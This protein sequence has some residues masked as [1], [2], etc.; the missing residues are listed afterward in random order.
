MATGASC[1]AV[2]IELVEVDIERRLK[3]GEPACLADYFERYPQLAAN[4]TVVYAPPQAERSTGPLPIPEE[5]GGYRI[6]RILGQGSFGVVYLGYDHQLHR[7]VAIKVPHR[8]LVARPEDAAPYRA[9]ARVVAALNHPNIVPV[10]HVGSAADHPF[11]IVSKFIKG[12]TLARRI[13]LFRPSV[14]EAAKLA[15]VVADAL[16]YAHRQ[17][18]VHRDIKPG[19][20]LLERQAGGGQPLL[21]YVADFGL[22][23]REQDFGKGAGRVGTPAYMSPE[24]ARGEGN[25]V[26]GRSDIFSLGVVFYELLTGVR[27]FQADTIEGILDQI[28]NADVRPPRQRDDSIPPELER[29]CLK[30]LARRASERYTTAKDFA[31]DLRSFLTETAA[32]DESGSGRKRPDKPPIKIVP[33]GLR[34]FQAHDADFFLELLPGPRDRHGLPD[35]IR[36][37][38]TRIEDKDEANTFSVG[39]IYGPSG[40]GKSSLVKAGLL[41]RLNE[42]VIAVYIEASTQETEA[43]L[44]SGLR[45][46]FDRETSAGH[47][48]AMAEPASLG[49]RDTL[50]AVRR[51]QILPSGK[52]VLIVLDQFEQWLHGAASRRRRR[53]ETDSA[54]LV[55]ALRQCDGRRVQCLVMVRDDFWLAVSRFLQELE[56]PLLEGQNS[57]LVDLFDLEHAKKVLAAFGRAF[58][59]LP[60]DPSETSKEQRQFLEQAVTDL[61][62]EGK[63][64]CV[65]L[66]LFAEMMKSK[67]WT[68]GSLKAVGGAT[69]ISAKFLEETFGRPTAPPAHLHHRD[70]AREVLQALLPES[71]TN[72][73]GHMRSYQQLLEASG[74]TSGSR[75]TSGKNFDDLLH[76]LDSDLRLITP[77]DPEGATRD[78]EAEIRGARHGLGNESRAS[79]SSS[80]LPTPSV[81]RRFYQLTHDYLVHSLRDWLS[82]EEQ[83][84]MRGRTGLLMKDLASVYS[85]RTENRQLPSFFQWIRI[86][87][88]TSNKTWTQPQRRMMG[89]AGRYHAKRALRLAVLLLLSTLVGLY[90]YRANRAAELV[91]FLEAAE[92]A[93]VPGIV[94]EIAPYR[95]WANARLEE[96]NKKAAADSRRKL[97]TSMALLPVQPEQAEYL[98]G[99]LLDA[100]LDFGR[101]LDAKPNLIRVILDF[102]ARYPA[103]GDCRDRIL[104]GLV[105]EV[106]KLPSSNAEEDA[107]ETLSRRQAKAA[108]ALLRMN[109]PDQV[110]PL[111]KHRED[112]RVRSYLIHLLGPSGV[113]FKHIS[114][115]LRNE[116]DLTIRQALV[117]SLGDFGEEDIAGDERNALVNDLREWYVHHPDPGLHGAAEWLLRQWKQ[118][119]WL[120]ET[121]ERRVTAKQQSEQRR[122]VIRQGFAKDGAA[123]RVPQW[124]VNSQGQTMVV[125][126]S[127]T[128]FMMGSPLKEESRWPD[129]RLQQRQNIG[130]RFA[131]AAKSVTVDQFRR[132]RKSHGPLALRRPSKPDC[133]VTWLS[134]HLAAEYCNWLSDQEGLE[135]CYEPIDK[136]THEAEMK[137]AANC[138]SRTGYRLPTEEEWECACRAGTRTSR[139]YGEPTELLRKYG[140]YVENSGNRSWEVA[141]LKPNDWGLF[142]MHGNV[143]NW[144]H[145]EYDGSRSEN[146]RFSGRLV[147]R[148]G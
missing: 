3:C 122:E 120:K 97:N 121:D 44:L 1:R 142:D 72:I 20:I 37:W 73:K 104:T 45:R 114:R 9:E 32:D 136:E 113:E 17:G 85:A 99:R 82:R 48:P 36:F 42:D 77:C 137:P 79:A 27:P 115:Q 116:S 31:D 70:A 111:L 65:H 52:K 25:R 14:H 84:T 107:R 59:K 50:T 75:K 35:S 47:L 4:P 89:M 132:F 105:A 28:R 54:D 131:I 86:R 41:P 69:G 13:R 78:E 40:C 93:Q 71:G 135:R 112:P 30:A 127:S 98:Y 19:N 102:A 103:Q 81:A 6:E 144:C 43:R 145:N 33:K 57:A 12:G 126:P 118:D 39:L 34:S 83:A 88:L 15:C 92:I 53:P 24:Q 101:L 147:C 129:E 95:T 67:A 110:W 46:R 66:A 18:L 119:Q 117:L 51:G 125:I 10:Y 91:R 58:G 26:N 62:G 74:Y 61:A 2:L 76:I 106:S 148:C 140:W 38:K 23:L 21:P 128:Q 130:H 63:V 108:V 8:K 143:W 123:Q 133:P 49:L 29:A 68:P 146:R 11:F 134:W 94:D 87:L 22:A 124:Y 55:E 5:I 16:H 60:Q 80:G 138:L 7:H 56:V 64:I 100:D 90:A 141:S 109:Q 139:Y 96:S